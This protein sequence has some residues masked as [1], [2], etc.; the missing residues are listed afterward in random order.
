MELYLP[1]HHSWAV[2]NSSVLN[3]FLQVRKVI[4]K[5]PDLVELLLV[6]HHQDVALAVVQDVPHGIRSVGGVYS[7]GEATSKDS[8]YIRNDPL[9]GV[10]AED[11][12][13][14]ELVEAEVN[15]GLGDSPN[16]LVIRRPC[17]DGLKYVMLVLGRGDCNIASLFPSV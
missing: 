15:E 6:L 4:L 2:R 10:E 16:L 17:P 5:V 11:T 8:S 7:R 9:G 1:A 12:D 14:A 13:R 3:N